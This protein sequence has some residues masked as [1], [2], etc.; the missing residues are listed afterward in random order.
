MGNRVMLRGGKHLPNFG[1]PRPRSRRSAL[2]LRLVS[3]Q[4]LV[5]DGEPRAQARGGCIA[6]HP[7]PPPRRRRW[8]MA[9]ERGNECLALGPDPRPTTPVRPPVTTGWPRPDEAYRHQVERVKKL[10][11]RGHPPNSPGSVNSERRLVGLAIIMR[12]LASSSSGRAVNPPRR[13]STG[14]APPGQHMGERV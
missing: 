4:P 3:W 13:R 11:H 1:N 12:P 8:T 7:H 9:R 2:H 5:T 10:R 6:L 14:R